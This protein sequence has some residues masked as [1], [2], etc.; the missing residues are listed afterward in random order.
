MA[1]LGVNGPGQKR[2]MAFDFSKAFLYG[3]MQR[4]VFIELPDEDARKDGKSF[5]GLLRKSMYGLR[6]APQILQRVVQDMFKKRGF[7]SLV[8]TQCM[9]VNERR[10]DCC[11]CRWLLM[12]W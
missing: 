3:D 10:Y 2:L 12:L 7:V 8:T 6:D 1:S 5:V 4:R 9:Y 11:A